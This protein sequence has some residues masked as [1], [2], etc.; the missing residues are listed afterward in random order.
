[1]LPQYKALQG[2]RRIGLTSR[3]RCDEEVCFGGQGPG[4]TPSNVTLSEAAP[5][6][7]PAGSEPRLA[8]GVKLYTGPCKGVS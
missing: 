1:M 6:A 8:R 4:F 5:R 3:R 2:I 7:A